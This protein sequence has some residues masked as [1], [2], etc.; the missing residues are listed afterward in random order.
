M[1]AQLA[2]QLAEDG[3]V[4]GC[5]DGEG[6]KNC[7]WQGVPCI[8]LACHGRPSSPKDQGFAVAGAVPVGAGAPVVGEAWVVGAT[9]GEAL[10]ATVGETPGAAVGQGVIAGNG[11]LVRVVVSCGRTLTFVE[12]SEA[13]GLG[14]GVLLV[15]GAGVE[16]AV[17]RVGGGRSMK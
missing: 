3:E 10:G 8:W 16:G 1:P 17:A 14:D 4:L 15:T 9:V 2:G 13:R 6:V 12:G 7:C 5:H 11:A